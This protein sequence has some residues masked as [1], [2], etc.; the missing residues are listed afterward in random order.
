MR[1]DY[2]IHR[3]GKGGWTQPRFCVTPYLHI[4]L[5]SSMLLLSLPQITNS[6]VSL[7]CCCKGQELWEMTKVMLGCDMSSNLR[8][9]FASQFL[10]SCL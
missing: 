8:E 5:D 1:R 3:A 7:L 4:Y 2:I 6:C 9:F 10:P